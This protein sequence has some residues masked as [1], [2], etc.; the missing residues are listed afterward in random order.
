[1]PPSGAPVATL[2]RRSTQV[3]NGFCILQCP[4]FNIP[5][6]VPSANFCHR[7]DARPAAAAARSRGLEKPQRHGPRGQ[8]RRRVRGHP[9]HARGRTHRRAS[10]RPGYRRRRERWAGCGSGGAGAAAPASAEE[11]RR[12]TVVGRPRPRARR[13]LVADRPQCC[14]NAELAARQ[15]PPCASW[16]PRRPARELLRAGGRGGLQ[17]QDCP[18]TRFRV[19]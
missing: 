11:L 18:P 2:N 9:P 13:G 1:M 16:R 7:W 4:G 5:A 8:W 12:P 19:Q 17:A 15:Q 10:C 14:R 3:L 6:R